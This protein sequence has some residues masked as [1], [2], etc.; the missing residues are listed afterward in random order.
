M[1]YQTLLEYLR[2]RPA[3]Y[4]PSTHKFW[5]EEHIAGRMLE[6]HLDPDFEGAS[7]KHEFIRRSAA[8]IAGLAEP[9][10]GKKLLDL[11]CGPG[12]YAERF[13][14]AGFEVAGV[15]LSAN[16]VAYAAK[17]AAETGKSI[18]Y[19]CQNYLELDCREQYD[20]VTL[21]YCDF[22]VL[23]PA[24]RAVL[25]R[26]AYRALKP[27]G[28][29]VLDAFTRRQYDGF[30]QR[31]TVKVEEGGFWSPKP[32]V[33]VQSDY[34]YEEPGCFLEQYVVVTED[35]CRCYNLWNQAFDPESLG[36]E[37]EAAGF[38]RTAYYGD[39]CGAPLT[40]ESPTLCAVAEK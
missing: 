25:L 6:A 23:C 9:A 34:R 27:G 15:D 26:N 4:A 17:H 2:E 20:A 1:S 5:D 38:R 33:C 37:L 10:R 40:E 13:W 8:W 19:R 28:V 32:Y 36:A 18:E 29:L 12:L 16:S 14:E 35:E 11:G 7:R 31:R 3:E 39:V 24:D 21:I 30:A 22:G